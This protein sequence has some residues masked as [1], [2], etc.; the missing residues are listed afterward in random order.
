MLRRLNNG[1]DTAKSTKRRSEKKKIRGRGHGASNGLRCGRGNKGQNARSGGGVRPGF[2]G[3]QMPLYRRIARRG[4]TNGPF[5]KEYTIVN[6]G[7][8][9][10]KFENGDVVNKQSL[11]DKGLINKKRVDVKILGEGGISKKLKIDVAKVSQAAIAKITKCGGELIGGEIASHRPK[12]APRKGA[13]QDTDKTQQKKSG[14]KQS[15]KAET[16]IGKTEDI[17]NQESSGAAETAQSSPADEA[18][19]QSKQE[20]ENGN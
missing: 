1:G 15:S 14:G 12:D 10:K 8:L 13:Q 7:Q 6:V 5:K 18:N 16:T 17:D 19:T 9:E 20:G 4:F 11:L 3:G 2:E